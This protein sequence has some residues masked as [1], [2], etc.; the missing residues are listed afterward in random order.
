MDF[1]P[2]IRS[3]RCTSSVS[4]LFSGPAWREV[5]VFRPCST[6]DFRLL[7]FCSVYVFR[8]M[9][10][11]SSFCFRCFQLLFLFYGFANHTLPIRSRLQSD[12]GTW[13]S[14]F[15]GALTP[16]TASTA[17]AAL[18]SPP[19]FQGVLHIPQFYLQLCSFISPPPC[20]GFWLFCALLF[21]WAFTICNGQKSNSRGKIL[22]NRFSSKNFFEMFWK[23]FL[24]AC[25]RNRSIYDVEIFLL[26]SL[27]AGYFGYELCSFFNFFRRSWQIC[28]NDRKGLTPN[29]N[30]IILISE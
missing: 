17:C 6:Q 18:F 29:W 10:A 12:S 7:N 26:L 23:F 2:F 15:S 22:Q 28:E 8:T 1:V 4:V 19:H 3:V 27:H 24:H 25:W 14:R 5:F 21:C 9:C 16:P 13:R 30:D 20:G 11:L